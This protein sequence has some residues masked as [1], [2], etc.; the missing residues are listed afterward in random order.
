MPMVIPSGWVPNPQVPPEG[1]R[2]RGAR[3]QRN[4]GLERHVSSQRRREFFG[5]A[6]PAR[7][8]GQVRECAWPQLSR[9]RD[10]RRAAARFH[11][12]ASGLHPAQAGHP[13]DPGQARP[14][15]MN[16]L[17]PFK[18]VNPSAENVARHFYDEV[19]RQLKDLP[20]GARV[21]D[22]ILWETDTS[23]AQYR[24]GA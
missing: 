13:R 5:R 9:A 7:L 17:E 24:P 10:A 20:P 18:A 14:Q 23:R 19:T 15:F 2:T 1:P 22:V 3:R 16:E 12:A 11:R 6:R 4:A 21:T 8:P